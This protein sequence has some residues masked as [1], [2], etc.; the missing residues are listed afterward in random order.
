MSTPASTHPRLS[1][2]IPAFNE[3]ESVGELH[4]QIQKALCDE[5]H[6]ILFVDDGSTD[7]TAEVLDEL[8]A[9]DA[10]VRVIHLAR[11]H[12][13]SAAYMAGFAAARG[14]IIVT[15]DADLQDVPAEVPR[16]V[17]ALDEGADLAV[18]WKRERLANEPHKKLPSLLYN[19]AKGLLFG[20][21]IHDSNCGLRAMR[22]EAAQFLRL[23]GDHY[24]FI[25]ELLHQAGFRVVEVPV[26]HRRRR[27]GKSKYGPGRFVTGLLDLLSVRF[28]TGFGGRPLHFLGSIALALLASGALMELYVLA[29]KLSGSTFRTH[30]AA[31]I[32]GVM[33]LVVG[34]Q[35]L[36]IGLIGE[37][38]AEH[39]E[40]PQPAIRPS[41]HKSARKGPAR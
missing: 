24:R 10:S 17:A 5:P 4:A 1:L 8:E 15:L 7:G 11:N 38:L 2:V 21:R 34:V 20:L 39:R 31:L 12:G 23:H 18:G 26:R 35:L 40:P 9:S 32:I 37:M 13:K 29:M 25:P 33:L 28:I 36:A 30:L 6:E 16:L 3:R 41:R 19:S 22:R 27:H 14:E